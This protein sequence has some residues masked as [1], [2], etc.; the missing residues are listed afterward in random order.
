MSLF[1]GKH[2]KT[3]LIIQFLDKLRNT[4]QNC[5]QLKHTALWSLP[6]PYV[7]HQLEKITRKRHCTRG[8]GYSFVV[9]PSSGLGGMGN[10][11][12][13]HVNAET[14]TVLWNR[15]NQTVDVDSRWTSKQAQQ[16]KDCMKFYPRQN[17][18]SS[19]KCTLTL[20]SSRSDGCA[21]KFV[22]CLI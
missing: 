12:G 19:W 10:L 15:A 20:L 13:S 11:V 14:S 4:N 16:E 21:Y 17:H 22:S 5:T 1:I 3:A 18:P 8:K 6:L 7:C 9:E 2:V